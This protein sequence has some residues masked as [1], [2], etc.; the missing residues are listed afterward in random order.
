MSI[1]MSKII[2][3]II[4]SAIIKNNSNTMPKL[5]K[6]KTLIIIKIKNNIKINL[7]F[8]RVK[9]LVREIINKNH[10]TN[11]LSRIIKKTP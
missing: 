10:N 2:E 4:K 8:N 1:K 5:R 7:H 6:I 3:M 11:Q 9:K